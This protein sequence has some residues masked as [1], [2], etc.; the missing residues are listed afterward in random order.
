MTITRE[1]VRSLTDPLRGLNYAL[2]L[3][4][5]SFPE[6]TRVSGLATAGLMGTRAIA[7]SLGVSLSTLL[8]VVGLVAAAVGGGLLAWHEWNAGEDEA[9]KKAKDVAEA[10]KNLI[11][12]LKQ[13]QDLQQA[14]LMSSAAGAEYSDYITEKKKLYRSQTGQITTSPTELQNVVTPFQGA[15]AP[16]GAQTIR[17]EMMPL[18]R[19]THA[20]I[21]DWVEDQI[22]AGG[23]IPA[24]QAAKLKEL[25]DLEKK[26]HEE[27]LS[28]LDQEKAAIHDKYEKQRVEI[29]QTAKAAGAELGDINF[30]NTPEVKATTSAISDTRLAEA[31]DIAEKE[32]E[33]TKKAITDTAK[34]RD[35]YAKEFAAA[36][37]KIDAD[38]TSQAD[39]SGQKRE[40]LYQQEYL[41]RAA[42]AFK[43]Y[44]TGKLSEDAYA[45][46]IQEAEHK[47]YDGLAKSNAELERRLQIKRALA[48]GDAEAELKRIQL[49][50]DLTNREKAAKSVGPIQNQLIANQ[51]YSSA[52]HAVVNNPATSDDA[53]LTALEKINQL[54]LRQIGLEDQLQK[55]EQQSGNFHQRFYADWQDHLTQ[56]KNQWGDLASSLSSGAFNVIQQG[57]N[58]MANALTGLILGTKNAGAAF[59]QLGLQLLTSFISTILEAVIYAEVA[60]PILTALGVLSGG[61]TVGSGAAIT[62]AAVG[63]AMSNVTMATARA[64]GGPV[65]AGMPYIIGEE[66]REMMIP[67]V[68]GTIL[69]NRSTEALLAGGAGGTSQPTADGYGGVAANGGKPTVIIVNDRQELLNFL[70]STDASNTVI[71]HVAQNK[72]RI[73]IPT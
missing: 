64:S 67:D 10:F 57:V 7:V 45:S 31:K 19:A 25:Q 39:E 73:G 46:A 33:F 47:L 44:V 13:I 51:D 30:A 35:Q 26:A 61:A 21:H 5:G 70:K 2:L 43:F 54:T 53:R 14:G 28:K 4:G 48:E 34:I 22:S 23:A 69:S 65:T 56:L 68:S 62:I 3:A 40:E 66:G 17:Q 20:E 38:I 11:P 36:N 1:G 6:L 27:T 71:A 50:P 60:I 8:P 58:G 32:A 59:V 9:E 16:A 72:T 49:N 55:A 18:P 12:I 63:A 42:L 41:Q 24:E 29:L 37:K 15:Y 52:L